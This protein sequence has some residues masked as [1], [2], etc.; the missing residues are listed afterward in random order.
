MFGRIHGFFAGELFIPRLS[1]GLKDKRLSLM[2]ETSIRDMVVGI[3]FVR[4]QLAIE[5]RVLLEKYYSAEAQLP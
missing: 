1:V 4:L 5:D 2:R 3:I